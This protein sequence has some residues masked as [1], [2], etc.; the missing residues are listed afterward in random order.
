[1]SPISTAAHPTRRRASRFAAGAVALSLV[2]AGALGAAP[3]HAAEP[4]GQGTADSLFPNV[5]NT[6]YDVQHYDIDLAY[7]HA[8]TAIAATAE[9]TAEADVELSS[10]S[11]DLEGLT[12]GSVTIDGAAATFSRVSDLPS[13]THKL[14]VTPA[15]PVTGTFTTVVEYSGVPTRH[16]DPDGSY[17]G[18]VATADGATA[19]SEPV[20][21]MTWFP[22]NNTPLDKA[23]FDFSFTIPTAITTSTG[24]GP[25]AA[26]SNGELIS[27]TV[28]ADDTTTWVW[29][30][31]E[32]M[33][34]YLSLASIGKYDVHESTITLPSGRTIP[35]WSFIDSDLSD[36]RKTTSLASRAEIGAVLGWLETAY[37]PYPGNSTGIVVDNAGVGYALETQDRS[38]FDRSASRGTLIHELVHQWFGDAVTLSDWSDIWLNEGPAEHITSQVEASL[39]DGDA[40][41]T[42]WYSAWNDTAAD[43]A[44]WLTPVAG[45]DDPAELFGFQA[46]SRSAMA[47]EALRLTI[48]DD[49]FDE[50]FRQWYLRLNGGD[51]S[52]ADFIALSE[53]ISGLDLQAF[54]QDW[55]FDLDKPTWPLTR[56]LEISPS[57]RSGVQLERG[58][59]VQYTVEVGNVGPTDLQ[60]GTVEIDLTGLVGSASVLEPLAAGLT[61]S[62]DIL[63][64]AV[65][66]VAQGA[67][68]ASVSFTATVDD[69]AT[70]GQ[71]N[72]SVSAVDFGADCLLC[73]S[74]IGV[75]QPID[76]FGI[77]TVSGAPIV[78]QTLTA[79]PGVWAEGTSL[80]YEWLRFTADD[81]REYE[82]MTGQPVDPGFVGQPVAG[83]T[84]ST[85]TLQPG[86]A[87]YAFLVVVTGTLEGYGAVSSLSAPTAFV[88]AA[89]VPLPTTTPTAAPAPPGLA[90]TGGDAV[91]LGAAAFAAALLV[92][93]GAAIVVLRRRR[94]E[95]A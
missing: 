65:P 28:N 59:G 81:A 1:M 9:I 73:E 84:G 53:D 22:S 3:A 88:T 89:A 68:A 21:A 46:Y 63:T 56:T 39:Y 94:A 35:E 23:T 30:Q 85:Y 95:S 67:P 10:F 43:D 80:T 34:T 37:G 93:A 87:G 2:G 79:D 15:A 45:F 26:V 36:A 4:G 66:T 12:V 50:I 47:L 83:A 29:Q 31:R 70:T 92:A 27:R 6:G 42:V 86:D 16:T 74:S 71:L 44:A 32:Q 5:G 20:G 69:D 78:G 82:E 57:T 40:I 18:W 64:W 51:G 19:V 54:F 33:T 24:T 55:L 8:T 11:L 48:G 62:G 76:P 72:V 90:A 91:P 58:Q 75:V 17:E 49:E 14:I 41:E 52:T 7:D 60:G 25:A 61:R 13:T 38:F 77:A